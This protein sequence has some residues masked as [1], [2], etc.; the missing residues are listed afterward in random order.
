VELDPNSAE[1]RIALGGALERSG[2]LGE[3]VE[4]Y[5][6][7]V[8]ANPKQPEAY[9]RLGSLFFAN[10]RFEDAAAALEKAVAAAPKVSRYR[11]AL[12]DA[13]AKLGRHEEAAR[14]FREVMKLDPAAVQAV[15]KLAR[16]V[17]EGEGAK[18]A[19]TLYERAAKD[20]PRNPMPHYYLGYLYK[21]RGQKARAAGEFRRFL[22]LKPDADEKRDIEAELED[23]GA[24]R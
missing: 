22:E 14:T 5:R 24:A 18:P 16:A 20:E 3:A 1:Y 7:A 21:E 12:G 2:A 15:Y 6:A 13:R 4:E 17:H 9:E 8:A 23:L 11:I 10:G 19:L